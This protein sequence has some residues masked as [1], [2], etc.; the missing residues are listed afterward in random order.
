MLYFIIEG[1]FKLKDIQVLFLE[2]ITVTKASSLT[3]SKFRKS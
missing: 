2:K 3:V 1:Y